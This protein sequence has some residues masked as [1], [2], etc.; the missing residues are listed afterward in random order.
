MRRL[1]DDDVLRLRMAAQHL[2]RPRRRPAVDLVRHLTGVQAQ[3]LS[4]AG[5]A[6]RARTGGLTSNRV[7]QARLI[8]RSIVLTWAMRGTLHLVCAEDYGWLVPLVTE[9][10]TAN[11]HRR[12]EHEGVPRGQHDKAVRLVGKILGQEGPLT[13]REIAEELAARAVRTKGQA[14]AHLVWL[15]AAEGILCYGPPAGRDQRLVLVTDWL[16]HPRSMERGAALA[17]LAA[18]YLSAHGPAQ[19]VDLAHWSGLRPGDARRAWAAVADR[20]VE[21]DTARG[22]RWVLRSRRER[23][24]AGIVRLLPAFDEYL[25]GWKDREPTA[26][27]TRWKK[28]NR[29]G[30]W[31]RPVVLAGGRA[32]AT[33]STERSVKGMQLQVRSFSPLTAAIRRGVMS[34]TRDVE[35]FLGTSVSMVLH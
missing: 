29:G 18:R 35:R 23:A 14:I 32:V 25:L 12:L 34:E 26:P 10:R 7:D 22:P 30:G 8:D 9:P 27:P 5:L 15:A 2:H 1:A 17:E 11:A 19:P 4:A 13:R 6:L 28:I 20:L 16:G 31:L 33:W 21:V 24:S 3:V